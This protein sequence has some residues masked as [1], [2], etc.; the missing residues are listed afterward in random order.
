MS[1]NTYPTF[2]D[3]EAELIWL[4]G[5]LV[6]AQSA[7]SFQSERLRLR[8]HTWEAQMEL[9]ILHAAECER[10]GERIIELEAALARV[11]AKPGDA[12]VRNAALMKL[13]VKLGNGTDGTEGTDVVNPNAGVVAAFPNGRWAAKG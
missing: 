5:Q 1:E 3:Q 9:S 6:R 4:Q 13:Q 8:A 11:L 2:A 10:R 7:L 12:V